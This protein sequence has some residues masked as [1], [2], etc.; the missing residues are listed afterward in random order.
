MIQVAPERLPGIE[1]RFRPE[2]KAV[3]GERAAS[4]PEDSGVDDAADDL[5]D[6]L[7]AP[8]CVRGEQAE[9]VAGAADVGRRNG[10]MVVE[11]FVISP[12]PPGRR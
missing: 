7:M 3:V 5:D 11:R 9:A 2:S 10:G 8:I 1:I 4:I 6:R 12:K